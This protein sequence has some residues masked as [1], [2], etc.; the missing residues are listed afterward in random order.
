LQVP[1][2]ATSTSSFRISLLIADAA[3]PEAV[4]ALHRELVTE[5]EPV[6]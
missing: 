6:A 3:V 2:L 1:V 5:G 4:R